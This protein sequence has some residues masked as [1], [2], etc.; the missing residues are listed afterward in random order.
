MPPRLT[1]RTFAGAVAGGFSVL[2]GCLARAE[3]EA[4]ADEP[5]EPSESEAPDELEGS[6]MDDLTEPLHTRRCNCPVCR[7]SV[8]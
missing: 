4:P 3:S 6:S 5:V 8:E 2:A 1:R 7:G